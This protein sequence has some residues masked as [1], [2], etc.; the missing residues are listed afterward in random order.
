MKK[1]IRILGIDDAPFDRFKDRR[2]L[3]LGAF[4]RGGSSLDGVLSE[5]VEV[6]GTDSSDKI[7]RMV[8]K[9]R[10]YK[11]LRA[12]MMKGIA[13]AGFNLI[14]VE[15]VS[16]KTGIPVIVVMRRMPDRERIARILENLGK[17]RRIKLMEKAGEIH[18]AGSV[19]I[20]FSGTTLAGAREIVRISSTCGNVPE[21]VRAAHIIASG[22]KL[23][24]SR[25][26]A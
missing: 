11:Q 25:G 1:E 23:G 14:D 20:Q 26:R 6:D 10:F 13:V 3:L 9:S 17:K 19:L 5:T 16:K 12:I 8:R 2:T 18:G 21:P 22:I 15:K 24:H 4:F 7:I